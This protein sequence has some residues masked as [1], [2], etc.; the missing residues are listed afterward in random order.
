MTNLY[1]IAID[2]K[3][4]SETVVRRMEFVKDLIKKIEAGTDNNDK[5]VKK[6]IITKTVDNIVDELHMS[7]QYRKDS[8]YPE[9]ATLKAKLLNLFESEDPC[10]DSLR[11]EIKKMYKARLLAENNWLESR[12]FLVRAALAELDEEEEEKNV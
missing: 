12:T 3:D 4:I 8:E 7:F 1:S 2:Y 9:V 11:D 5:T 6:T 10:Y